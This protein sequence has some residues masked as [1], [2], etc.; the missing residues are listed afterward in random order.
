MT[1]FLYKQ[2][3]QTLARTLGT[4]QYVILFLSDFC[5]MKCR[6]C[7]FNEDWKT[8]NLG[9][10]T[11]TY[12][13]IEKMARSMKRILFLSLTGGE[14]F[15]RPDVVEI[16]NVFARETK[17]SRY[18]IPTSGFKTD[19]IISRTEQMLKN[20]PTIPF[21]VDVSLDGTETVHEKIRAVTGGH[22]RALETIRALNELKR[23]HRNFDVGVITTVSHDNQHEIPE[24]GRLVESVNPNGEWMVNIVRGAVRD[25]NA[26]NVEIG[27]YLSAHKLIRERIESGAYRGH[28]GHATASWLSAKNATRR[29]II[30]KRLEGRC[31]GG[32]CA[33]GSLGGVIYSDGTVKACEMLDQPLGNLR[34]YDCDLAALWNS[35]AAD[36]V[37][38]W[39]QDTRCQCTQECF[40]SISLL[41]QPQH[42]PDIVKE[43]LRL[44]RG[45]VRGAAA[46][47]VA[48]V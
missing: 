36:E 2:L 27:S 4:P 43:R 8:A 32:G 10:P 9:K 6:H 14:A 44:A 47:V 30:R 19:L 42:W 25:P 13:E 38:R 18:Q 35:P 12:D 40:L 24:I 37:R 28:G 11:L 39:I 22:R 34:D 1:P 29:K 15:T 20:H 23:H 16:V 33:A 31:S 7:W 5:W 45:R 48:T 17:M 41:I 26:H 46:P 3:T 21:R